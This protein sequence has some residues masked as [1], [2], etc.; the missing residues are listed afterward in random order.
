MYLTCP[1]CSATHEHPYIW[2]QSCDTEMNPSD[3]ANM[4]LV[5]VPRH[6]YMANRGGYTQRELLRESSDYHKSNELA[7]SPSR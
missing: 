1:R 7:G 2:C 6:F 3:P 5:L 4:P